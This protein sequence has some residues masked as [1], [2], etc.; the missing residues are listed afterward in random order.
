MK[1]LFA[2][3]A[4][5][6]VVNLAAQAGVRYS[7]DHPHTYIESNV[8]GF[9]NVLEGC[10]Y[11]NVKHLCVCIFKFGIWCKQEDAILHSR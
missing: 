2:E 7:I 8:T 11:H 6:Y 9:L 4:F 5:E 3:N 1:N 10:R